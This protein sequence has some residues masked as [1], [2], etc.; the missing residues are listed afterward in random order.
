MIA[1]SRI[2]FS[3]VIVVEASDKEVVVSG[4]FIPRKVMELK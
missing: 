3:S 2:K 1:V 4:K